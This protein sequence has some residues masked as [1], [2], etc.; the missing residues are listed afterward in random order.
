MDVQWKYE[1]ELM[2][3]R[4]VIG[5]AIGRNEDDLQQPSLVVFVE[6]G[7]APKHL[8]PALDGVAVR[9]IES[10]RFRAT[11]QSLSMTSGKCT[12][13]KRSTAFENPELH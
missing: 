11:L 10:G 3:D 2:L 6:A 9:V 1:N 4:A 7:K 13:Q 8:P 12:V 5:I